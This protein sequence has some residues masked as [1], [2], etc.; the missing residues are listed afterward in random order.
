MHNS[1]RKLL[2][3]RSRQPQH[4]TPR[5]PTQLR[6]GFMSTRA[7]IKRCSAF[8]TCFVS[9]RVCLGV[10]VVPAES[11][12]RHR[13]L[14]GECGSF[15]QTRRSL[16]TGTHC[17]VHI[18]YS[19]NEVEGLCSI[20]RGTCLQGEAA[21]GHDVSYCSH[22][23]LKSVGAVASCTN[24]DVDL[25]LRLAPTQTQAMPAPSR[26]VHDVV[27]TEDGW[28]SVRARVTVAAASCLPAC[29]PALPLL[30]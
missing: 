23:Q 14:R 19:R 6:H 15:L 24:A 26:G 12:H 4:N 20:V 29:L 9:L 7:I 25:A 27:Q 16:A 8:R 10:S 17:R 3:Q 30:A 18:G 5:L 28:P 2:A 1:A 21:P 11:G 13:P 22:H